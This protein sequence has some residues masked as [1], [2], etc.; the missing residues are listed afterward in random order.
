MKSH[1]VQFFSSDDNIQ[2]TM[3]IFKTQ[4][5]KKKNFS[6]KEM[7]KGEGEIMKLTLFWCQAKQLSPALCTNLFWLSLLLAVFTRAL[8]FGFFKHIY[9]CTKLPAS[10]TATEQG[11]RLHSI[12]GFHNLQTQKREKN[13]QTDRKEKR[14]RSGYRKK[15]AKKE[16]ILY[17]YTDA[18]KIFTLKRKSNISKNISYFKSRTRIKEIII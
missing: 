9:L 18:E 14:N 2:K 11:G 17:L 3:H 13:I 15:R 10:A 4:E 7:G 5:G 6:R 12:Q 1:V 8:I 16:E